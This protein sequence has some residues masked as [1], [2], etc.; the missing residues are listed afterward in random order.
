MKKHTALILIFIGGY[1]G[2]ATQLLVLRQVANFVG[3]TAIITSII[4][5]V[6]LAAMTAGYFFGGRPPKN[7]ECRIKNVEL[8]GY[9]GNNIAKIV[10]RN[11]LIISGLVFLAAS[12]SIVRSIFYLMIIAGIYSPIAQTFI[13]SALFLSF[14]PFLSGYTISLLAQTL[15][16]SKRDY[17]GV[18]MGVDTIGSVLGSLIT[19]LIIMAMFGVN[20]A[21]IITVLMSGIGVAIATSSEFRV[22]NSELMR[23]LRSFF[24]FI[25]I[26]VLTVG[27]NSTERLRQTYG[28]VS[29]TA[30]GTVAVIEDADGRH[31]VIDSATHSLIRPG[32]GHAE[33]I[34]FVNFFFINTI[35]PTVTKRIL[36]LG[37]GGFTL[38]RH[39]DRNEYVFV[40][41]NRNLKDVSERYFLPEPLGDNKRFVVQD[42]RQ[43]LRVTKDK[44]DIILMDAFS[45]WTIPEQLV[46]I[47]FMT[48]MKSVL[49]D[50]GVMIM[51]VITHP[52]FADEFSRRIDNSIRTVFPR[53]L[54]RH[55]ATPFNG[56]SE[57]GSA[58]VMYIYKNIPNGGRIYDANR[59]STIYHKQR[60]F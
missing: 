58:N 23:S 27:T 3:S 55:I 26:F 22:K 11:F 47:E 31:F 2:L 16:N 36:V 40:D 48:E 25:G 8:S 57:T 24:I 6:Y 50:G 21:V 17:T 54:S 1:V 44:Y 34:D 42:A 7:V 33:Y 12:Y 9:I 39:D 41:I 46:T 5:G 18:I 56:W 28:I 52:M 29:N 53:N 20:Y 45:R 60:E 51:N 38:G 43:Y 35:P 19:T 13:F 15:H 59:N 32:G 49:S 10:R 14:L 30:A 4:I 37:A